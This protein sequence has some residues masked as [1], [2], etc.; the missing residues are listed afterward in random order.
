MERPLPKEENGKVI[1]LMK[2]ENGGKIMTEF[3]A[4]KPKT[5]SYA[6]DVNDENKKA[7]GTKKYP[8]RKT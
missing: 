4:L 5:Y 6:I 8:K 3:A 2:D 7:R 1:G